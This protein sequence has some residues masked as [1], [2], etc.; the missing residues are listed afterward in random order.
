V[1]RDAMRT[2]IGRMGCMH[3]VGG[4]SLRHALL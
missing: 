1:S 3:G 4:G 2:F